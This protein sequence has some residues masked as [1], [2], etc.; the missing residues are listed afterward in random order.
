MG[1]AGQLTVDVRADPGTPGTAQ[2]NDVAAVLAV[3]ARVEPDTVVALAVRADP[4]GG[5]APRLSV[6]DATRTKESALHASAA[7]DGMPC[8]RHAWHKR[9]GPMANRSA[10]GCLCRVDQ[11]V[12]NVHRADQQR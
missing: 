9:C 7:R 1:Q 11:V 10:R 6:D 3:L 4:S 8:D 5:L 2:M 12:G